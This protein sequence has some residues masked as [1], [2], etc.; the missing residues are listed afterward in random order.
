MKEILET[1]EEATG[2]NGHGEGKMEEHYWG[3]QGQK[4]VVETD[5]EEEEEF[6]GPG[7][8][9]SWRTVRCTP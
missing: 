5:E 6:E 8:K 9:R 4:S 1:L 2:K 3:D 7:R